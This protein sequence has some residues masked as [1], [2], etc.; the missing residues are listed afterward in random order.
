MQKNLL[1]VFSIL[2]FISCSTSINYLGS[3]SAPT[4]QV[5]VYVN[6]AAIKKAYDIVGKGYV[7]Y[8][9]VN[10][11]TV[12]KIQNKAID[13]AKQKGADAV[14]I[15]DYFIPNT[16]TS[17]NTTTRRDSIAKGVITERNT[18]VQSTGSSG[19]TILFLKYS[20]N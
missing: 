6:E 9:I 15:K 8:G 20:H 16:G 17:I 12:E 4:S 1:F 3:S 14:L 5:D 18:A 7:N 11:K 19:Y 2:N 10:N 13:K